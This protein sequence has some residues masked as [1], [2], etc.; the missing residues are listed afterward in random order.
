MAEIGAHIP[1][2]E[3]LGTKQGSRGKSY[4]ITAVT[5]ETGL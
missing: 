3:A 1:V 5:Q 4:E 2:T